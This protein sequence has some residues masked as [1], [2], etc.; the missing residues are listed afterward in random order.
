MERYSLITCVGMPKLTSQ[1]ITHEEG[2]DVGALDKEGF[3]KVLNKV[4]T[5][6]LHR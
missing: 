2:V 4:S 5:R 6:P 3:K 1:G